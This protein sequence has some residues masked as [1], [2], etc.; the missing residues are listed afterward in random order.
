MILR[1]DRLKCSTYTGGTT[2]VLEI[3]V[4]PI[5]CSLTHKL[6]DAH[7]AVHQRLVEILSSYKSSMTSAGAGANA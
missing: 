6:E 1:F 7:D 4:A 2:V 5:E 3:F